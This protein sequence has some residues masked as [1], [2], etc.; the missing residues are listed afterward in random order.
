VDSGNA[1][2]MV[3]MIGLRV[4]WPKAL[5]TLG[6]SPERWTQQVK[7]DG[8]G[9]W[10]EVGAC[11]AIEEKAVATQQQVLRG[12]GLARALATG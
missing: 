2:W 12:V 10:R 5:K 6:L 4:P 11:V 8:S 9:F 3:V 7:G 1:I